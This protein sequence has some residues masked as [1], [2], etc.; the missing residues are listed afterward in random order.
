MMIALVN[1]VLDIG[2]LDA[3]KRESCVCLS[4]LCWKTTLAHFAVF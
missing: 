3:G 1:D 2:K 4:L